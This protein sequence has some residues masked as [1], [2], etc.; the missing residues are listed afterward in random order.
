MP[1]ASDLCIESE[2]IAGHQFEKPLKT[3]KLHLRNK[4]HIGMEPGV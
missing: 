2:K 3:V 1:T 4:T